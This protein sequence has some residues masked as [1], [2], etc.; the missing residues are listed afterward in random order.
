MH[1]E[2]EKSPASAINCIA[3]HHIASHRWEGPLWCGV[4]QND[5]EETLMIKHSGMDPEPPVF[6]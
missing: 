6:R 1:V 5:A 3:S 2:K 4:G